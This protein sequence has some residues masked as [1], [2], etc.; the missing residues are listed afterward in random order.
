MTFPTLLALVAVLL[1]VLFVAFGAPVFFALAFL[2]ALLSALLH[3]L[4][5]SH[6][7]N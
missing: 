7:H 4:D 1:G 3:G 2:S 6:P 5:G